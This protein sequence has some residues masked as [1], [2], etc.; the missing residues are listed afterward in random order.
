MSESGTASVPA[1]LLPARELTRPVPATLLA[2]TPYAG[3]DVDL[4]AKPDSLRAAD[5][6]AHLASP[7]LPLY[8]SLRVLLA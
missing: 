2:F 6:A 8:L 7:H 4:P 1:P 3:A 5:D